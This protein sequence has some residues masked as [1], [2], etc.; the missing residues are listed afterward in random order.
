MKHFNP[1]PIIALMAA[2]LPAIASAQVTTKPDGVFRSLF[3]L[4][5]SASDGNTRAASLA[6]TGETVQQTTYSK[7]GMLGRAVYA[8]D[9]EGTTAQ[10]IVFGTQ[11]DRDITDTDYFGVAKFDAQRDRLSNLNLRGSA[12]GGI[13]KHLIRN[14][15]NTWDAI[16]GLGYTQ[17]RYV[18]A[19]EVDGEFRRKYGYAEGVISENSNHKLTANTTLRQKLELYPNLSNSGEFRAVFDIGLAVAMTQRLQLTT[20]VTYRYNSDPGTDTKRYDTLFLT[21]VSLRFD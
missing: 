1:T 3:G 18:T 8:R 14:D 7:W 16:V 19:T 5:G 17:D 15:A 21:G 9:D 11:Y 4:S 2:A 12:Y 13:G 10:N 20:G 6:I